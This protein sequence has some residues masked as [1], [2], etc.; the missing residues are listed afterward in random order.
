MNGAYCYSPTNCI[1]TPTYAPP[2]SSRGATG[3]KGSSSSS[4]SNSSTSS[5][6]AQWYIQQSHNAIVTNTNDAD[7][8]ASSSSNSSATSD[9]T[10]LSGNSSVSCGTKSFGSGVVPLFEQYSFAA[11]AY[12]ESPPPSDIPDPK[13]TNTT[14][15]SRSLS[16]KG[17]REVPATAIVTH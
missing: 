14:S 15:S 12:K 11:P 3:R 16:A 13:L 8:T 1:T 10:K 7:T 17:S 5:F 6:L 9:R 4:S 2:S